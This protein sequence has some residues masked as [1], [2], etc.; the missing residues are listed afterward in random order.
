MPGPSRCEV[1]RLA[2]SAYIS[3][4]VHPLGTCSACPLFWHWQ[5]HMCHLRTAARCRCCHMI[6]MMAHDVASTLCAAVLPDMSGQG[7]PQAQPAAA[8]LVMMMMALVCLPVHCCWH[9]TSSRV[10]FECMFHVQFLGFKVACCM[11]VMAGQAC[12]MLPGHRQDRQGVTV[13][14]PVQ[15]A[16]GSCFMCWCPV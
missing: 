14:L 16:A 7:G 2:P 9:V 8:S 3:H 10:R 13:T 15:P 4:D 6:I 5:W 1:H 11:S 12:S